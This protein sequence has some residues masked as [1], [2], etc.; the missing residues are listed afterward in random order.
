MVLHQF[1]CILHFC[2]MCSL[3]RVELVVQF[4]VRGSTHVLLCFFVVG[5]GCYTS[6]I[7]S[8]HIQCQAS[9]YTVLLCRG[10]SWWVRLAKQETL[11]PP[12]HLVSPLIC[13]GP[14]MST[15]CS[16]VGATVEVHQFF[17]ILHLCVGG[18]SML[19]MSPFNSV[20]CLDYYT[21]WRTPWSSAS[22]IFNWTP[23]WTTYAIW[24]INILTNCSGQ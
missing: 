6:Y 20:L 3:C 10:H 17:C 8:V 2:H 9:I 24:N 22:W 12:R 11:T 19:Q 1:F 4:P 16:I 7:M 23:I 15:R 18:C 21:I 5:C 14:W 13:R